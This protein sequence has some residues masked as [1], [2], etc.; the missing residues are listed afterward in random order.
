VGLWSLFD[1]IMQLQRDVEAIK[2][3]LEE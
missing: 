3:K 2:R 1:R